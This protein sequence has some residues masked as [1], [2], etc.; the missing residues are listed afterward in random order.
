VSRGLI[1]KEEYIK[2]LGKKF[3]AYEEHAR[4][5][6]NVS[7]FSEATSSRAACVRTM[8][9][10]GEDPAINHRSRFRRSLA[11]GAIRVRGKRSQ[12]REFDTA[13]S[14]CRFAEQL[15]EIVPRILLTETRRVSCMNISSVRSA[16]IKKA[17]GTSSLG[18][19]TG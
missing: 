6:I 7:A 1:L 16:I 15:R 19:R 17:Y 11:A 4:K 14:T 13:T 10:S 18:R 8:L 3:C 9:L 5:R 2:N 12:S